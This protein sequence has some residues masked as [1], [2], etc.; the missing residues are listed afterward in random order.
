MRG[1]C[2]YSG[3]NDSRCSYRDY[4]YADHV[5]FGWLNVGFRMAR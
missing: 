4:S 1:G 2:W 3:Y 5:C